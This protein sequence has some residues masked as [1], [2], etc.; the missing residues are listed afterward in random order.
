L[1]KRRRLTHAGWFCDFGRC[2]PS[3]ITFLRM[4]RNRSCDVT[5]LYLLC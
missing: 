2:Y 3:L 4:Q 5:S 1:Q